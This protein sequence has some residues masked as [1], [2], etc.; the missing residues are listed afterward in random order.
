MYTYMFLGTFVQ[1][2]YFDQISY[3]FTFSR[4]YY[5]YLVC[6]M[7]VPTEQFVFVVA[8]LQLFSVNC[9][10]SLA[11]IYYLNDLVN[12]RLNIFTYF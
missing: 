1:H 10:I 6:I 4:L 2:G 5:H 11:R 12:D 9:P 8:G 7:C 3:L